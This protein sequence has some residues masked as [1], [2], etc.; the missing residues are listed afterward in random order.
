MQM[1]GHSCKRRAGYAL[2]TVAIAAASGGLQAAQVSQDH[3]ALL[4]AEAG[5]QRYARVLISLDQGVGLD[6]LRTNPAGIRAAM[7]QKAT[8]IR[9]LLGA[10]ALDAG[11]WDNG[12]G[13]L[14]LHV[15]VHGLRQLQATSLVPAFMPDI[16]W[17]T[18][19]RPRDDDGSLDAVE[20]RLNSAGRAMVDI[21]LNVAARYVL[22]PDGSTQ[23][24]PDPV[25]EADIA[26]N[27]PKL[28]VHPQATRLRSLDVGAASAVGMRLPGLRAM[29]D[30]EAYTWLVSSELV[31][32][33]RL[34]GW[35]DERPAR[36][37]NAALKAAQQKGEAEVSLTLK[38]GSGFSP[39]MGH[40]SAT[41]WARQ[42]E[43]NRKAFEDILA[44][45]G[46]VLD[47]SAMAL[48]E[49]TGTLS[50]R[51]PAAVIARL[52]AQQDKRVL[53]LDL[54]RPVA[55][56]QLSNSTQLMNMA[57]AWN[58][59]YRAAGQ[60]IVVLDTGVRK[61]HAMFMAGGSSRVAY[62]A[63]FGSNSDGYKSICPSPNASG[64]SPVGL[65]GS[66]ASWSNAQACLALNTAKKHSCEHGT[67]VTGIA[68]GRAT[69]LVRNGTLQGVA[70]DANIIAVQV[71]SY[72]GSSSPPR[73]GAFPDDI[74]A[75]LKALLTAS[76]YASGNP[77]V[78]N[79]S[80]GGSTRYTTNC[81]SVHSGITQ[82]IQQL[83]SVGVPVVV[84][85]G[86]DS[87]KDGLSWPACVP[88]TIKV[89]SVANDA[90]GTAVANFANLGPQ[91]NYIGPIFLAPGGHS[92]AG[93]ES[94]VRSAI[95]KTS[96]ETLGLRGT[97]MAAPHVAGVY[98]AVK[99]AVPGISVPDVSA[100]IASNA[101]IPVNVTLAAPYGTQTFPR[102]RLP[103]F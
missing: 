1:T 69:S 81:P 53:S 25:S 57:P 73:V 41:A 19:L 55:T 95:P 98:A 38:G 99:A 65:V 18:R 49:G 44:D 74:N 24:V 61:D 16:T 94:W 39:K 62:E 12:L 66:A 100:W 56:T 43:A 92:N 75:G 11:A 70:P 59:G 17:A 91:Q 72:D 23:Y 90:T 3:W 85:S 76:P 93:I 88:H 82:T 77:S 31:R 27:L 58:A 54:N 60:N 7:T 15:N 87:F 28:L 101:S 50:A 14:G 103:N 46:A 10:N 48:F 30:R 26:A 4:N 22:L 96:V 21:E 34:H 8:A 71:F 32:A 5:R 2:A 13:Q 67:H 33:V 68:A 37:D 51:L 86:N 102:V 84:A 63:C 80:I 79:M 78:V 52:F 45:A 97:S 83:T 29:V 6:T 36:W 20:Q 64:D 47:P 9:A 89:G 40:M 35:S 42:T